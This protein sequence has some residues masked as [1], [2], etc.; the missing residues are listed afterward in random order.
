MDAL[1]STRRRHLLLGG[2]G[3]LALAGCGEHRSSPAL[4]DGVRRFS[5]ETMGTVFNLKLADAAIDQRLAQTAADAVAA[6]FDGVNRRMSIYLADSEL[7]RFNA[8]DATTPLPLS[9]DLFAVLAAARE[10]STLTAGAFDV[11]VAPLVHAWGFGPN[12]RRHVPQASLVDV[13]RASVDYRALQLDAGARS[14]RKVRGN[15]QAD[16]GGIAKGYGVDLAA[17]ALDGLGIQRYM[18]EL[19]GEVRTRGTNVE[20]KPWQI[21]IERPDAWPPRAHYVLPL[22]GAAMATSGDYRIFFEQDGRRYSHEIDPRSG[23]PITHRLCS[24]TVV[25]DDCMRADALA[26]GLIVLGLERA[27]ALVEAKGLAAYFIVREADGSF[28]QHSS[29]AFAALGGRLV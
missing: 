16:L 7:S 18:L 24:V 13:Q 9:A 23:A 8:H 25:T 19:G 4:A 27:T 11:T 5:G 3:S 29:A 15:L 14:A 22:S 21:G 10:T 17:R 20:G 12:K 26:T 2:L 1:I 6:A 28:S